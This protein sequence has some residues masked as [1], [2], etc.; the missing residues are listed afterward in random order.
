MKADTRRALFVFS[1][2][3]VF[4]GKGRLVVIGGEAAGMKVQKMVHLDLS[5]APP[6]SPVWDPVLIAARQVEKLI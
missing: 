1:G 3:T 5:Y 2:G 4:M 6:Y